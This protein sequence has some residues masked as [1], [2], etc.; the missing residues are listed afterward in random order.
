MRLEHFR[1][2]LEIGKHGS[3]SSAARAL[4]MSQ[5]TL[6]S[7]VKAVEEELGFPIFQRTPNGVAPTAK[8]EKLMALAWEID[9]KYEELLHL[10]DRDKHTAQPIP[11][12]MAPSVN[13][14]LALPL[15][16]EFY[17]NEPH[18]TLVFEEL[19]RLEVGPRI[20]KSVA[21]LGLTYLTTDEICRFQTTADKHKVSITPLFTDHF[22]LFVRRDHYLANRTCVDVKEVYDEN[23]AT[24]TNFRISE[25]G[26]LLHS[27]SA[28]SFRFT[29]Y[30]SIPLIKQAVMEQNMVAILTGYAI[31]ADNSAA[32]R[33]C[34][35]VRLEGLDGENLLQICLLRRSSRNLR[36][37]ERVLLKCIE[38][39]FERLSPPPF[40]PEAEA[41]G[42]TGK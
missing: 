31:A 28:N 23:L 10:K 20:I 32:L 12:L 40:S 36:Y 18:A 37:P 8:G 38:G 6:S 41:A 34:R 16:G 9:V 39:Y 7:T 27:L 15:A 26:L 42:G 29:S 5:T 19:P 33:N 11:V 2:L 1:Y 21:N 25:S 3:I 14:G 17:R 30:P 13:T 24:A 35:A 22:Y 4:Y